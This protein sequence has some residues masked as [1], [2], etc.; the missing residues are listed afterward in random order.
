MSQ[1]VCKELPTTTSTTT[2]ST[3][4]TTTTSTTTTSTEANTEANT[5]EAF[6]YGDNSDRV[7]SGPSSD[8]NGE[9]SDD[10]Y[11]PSIKGI[12]NSKARH[13]MTFSLAIFIT[14]TL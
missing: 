8:G 2:T 7:P 9:N 3:T 6:G 12:T 5:N 11:P 4:T 10:R 13:V 14:C 1:K